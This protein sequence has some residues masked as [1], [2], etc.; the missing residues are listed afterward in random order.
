V[1][2]PGERATINSVDTSNKGRKLK[3]NLKIR[4]IF[5]VELSYYE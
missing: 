3:N 5:D 4:K 2:I 1:D